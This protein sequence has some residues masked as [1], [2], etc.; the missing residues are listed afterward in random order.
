MKIQGSV[1]GIDVG[2]SEKKRSSAV[3]RLSWDDRQIQWEIDRFRATPSDRENTIRR[4]AGESELLAVA[5]DGPLRHGFDMI[6]RYR[7]AERLLSRGQLQKRIGKPGQS[8]SPNGKKLNVQANRTAT[9]VKRCCRVREAKH[10]VRIDDRAIVEAFPTTFLGVMIEFPAQLKRPRSRSDR[11]FAHLA[12]HHCIGRFVQRLLGG[13]KC[14]HDPRDVKN[15]DDRAALVCALTALS[16]V[17]GEFTAVG[18][19]VDGWIILP[20]QWAFAGPAWAAAC[21][22]ARA[23]ALGQESAPFGKLLSFSEIPSDSGT[24]SPPA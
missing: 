24:S 10:G 12:E 8:S 7:S 9:F 5:I 11:Y 22:T 15:H 23:E 14:I 21:A 18:D 6:R 1:L 20:P 19:K 16:V 2:W 3:C 13:R 17:A 4:V